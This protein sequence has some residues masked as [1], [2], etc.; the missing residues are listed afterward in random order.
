MDTVSRNAHS[1]RSFCTEHGVTVAETDE[2]RARRFDVQQGTSRCVVK[3]YETG[4]VLV[5]GPTTP[6]RDTLMELKTLLE[7]GGIVADSAIA[8]GSPHIAF[9]PQV[10]DE[11]V[12]AL[13]DEARLCLDAHALMG[14]AY[15]MGAASERAIVQL[16]EAYRDA[17]VDA[18]RRERFATRI[19]GRGIK[20]QFDEFLQSWKSSTNRPDG[21]RG[22]HEPEMR[23]E[24]T[25]QFCRLCRNEASHPHI[26]PDLNPEVLGTTLA[27]FGRY[28]ADVY[29]LIS[30]YQQHP[31][32]F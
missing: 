18:T 16:I 8:S 29:K 20:Q 5:Q 28:L 24:Q 10:A 14:C 23:I 15:L 19:R 26:P 2:G 25:F 31:V 11:V 6:L 13:V 32:A 9:S 7:H 4:T 27:Y 21:F 30:Y 17:I 3:L 22:L 1:L 12:R